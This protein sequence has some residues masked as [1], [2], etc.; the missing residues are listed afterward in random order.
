MKLKLR[1]DI[2]KNV[3]RTLA[4]LEVRHTCVRSG[5][6]LVMRPLEGGALAW[7]QKRRK[8]FI[9]GLVPETPGA[10]GSEVL[11]A[12]QK[13]LEAAFDM[14]AIYAASV[15]VAIGYGDAV[16]PLYE[17]FELAGGGEGAP[18]EQDATETN[19][20]ASGVIL[21]AH[22]DAL[23]DFLRN[24]GDSDSVFPLEDLIALNGPLREIMSSTEE[25]MARLEA[26]PLVR[27]RL[28]STP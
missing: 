19:L 9:G 12:T 16:Y 22:R 13:D 6:T 7:S 15:T 28:K 17:A 21:D 20:G 11:I 25:L 23:V 3:Q 14:L 24:R 26:N 5:L 10:G 2:A 8:E 27:P 1:T 4:A 18:G